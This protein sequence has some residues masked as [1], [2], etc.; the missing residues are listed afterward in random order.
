[1]LPDHEYHNKPRALNLK[2]VQ[3]QVQPNITSGGIDWGAFRCPR[4]LNQVFSNECT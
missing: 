2:Q 4:K 3:V 1:M